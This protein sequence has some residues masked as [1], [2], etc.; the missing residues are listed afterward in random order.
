MFIAVLIRIVQTCKQPRCPSEG[1]LK[2]AVDP[3]N[4]VLISTKKKRAVIH[5]KT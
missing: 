1:N 5:E 4:G 3:G 2:S